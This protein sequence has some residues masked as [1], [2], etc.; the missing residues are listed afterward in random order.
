[1]TK[2]T[3]YGGVDEIGGNK[4]VLEDGDTRVSFDWGVSYSKLKKHPSM[5]LSSRDDL[6]DRLAYGILPD[7][8][9]YRGD[10]L[11]KIGRK[12]AA[13]PYLNAVILS[14]PHGDHY[15]EFPYLDPR[16]LIYCGVISR[17]VLEIDQDVSSYESGKDFCALRKLSPDGEIL[18][19]KRDFKIIKGRKIKIGSLEV[20]LFPVDH[21]VCDSYSF[22]AHTNGGTVV[23]TGD[24]R[25][26]GPR[27]DLS[28]K[29][30]HAAKEAKPKLLITEGT[31]IGDEEKDLTEEQ[32]KKILDKYLPRAKGLA[33]LNSSLRD[34]DIFNLYYQACNRCGRKFVLMPMQAYYLEN[35]QQYKELNIPD[36]NGEDFLILSNGNGQEWEEPYLSKKQNVVSPEDLSKMLD[37]ILILGYCTSWDT[38]RWNEVFKLNSGGVNFGIDFN[39]ASKYYGKS[40]HGERDEWSRSHGFKE[41]RGHLSGH[42]RPEDLIRTG[43]IINPEWATSVHT[44]NAYKFGKM[45]RGE[46]IKVLNSEVGKTID[47]MKL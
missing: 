19:D 11:E 41:V 33:L 23:Y 37:Q 25:F 6:G 28:E 12:P 34:V 16:I 2:L 31:R 27:R 10:Y 3:F 24:I 43:K 1:M 29:F 22:I 30:I 8:P 21:S 36:I 9:V 7:I 42:A 5:S 39:S 4:I 35:L 47:L 13:D 17:S 26:H 44:N 45:L 38:G 46:G 20:E 18:K 40:N 32:L 14:H 15:G